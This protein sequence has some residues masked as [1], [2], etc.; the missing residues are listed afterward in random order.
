MADEETTKN[1]FNNI[2]VTFEPISADAFSALAKAVEANARAISDIA[3]MAKGGGPQYGIY[4]ERG[5]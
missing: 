5:D 2:N 1:S 4:V 3:A